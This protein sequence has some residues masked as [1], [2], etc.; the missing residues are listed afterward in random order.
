VNASTTS[1]RFAGSQSEEI[2]MTMAWG[3]A[4]D[5]EIN[6]RHQQARNDFRRRTARRT[7]Q[8]APVRHVPGRSTADLIP[9]QPSRREPVTA[10]AA[11][12]RVSEQ[13]VSDAAGPERTRARA[14]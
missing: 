13:W 6:Y 8:P 3:P 1:T 5:A 7:A 14:A 12:Q 11:R 4:F 10:A 9:S 2:I